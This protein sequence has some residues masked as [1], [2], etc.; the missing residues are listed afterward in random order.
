MKKIKN[1]AFAKLSG[2]AKAFG[3]ESAFCNIAEGTHAGHITVVAKNAIAAANLVVKFDQGGIA[4]ANV[5]DVPAG[6]CTDSGDAGDI[7]DVALPGCAESSFI[8]ISGTDVKEGDN[9]Y[10]SNAGKVVKRAT[11]GSF[12]VGV[13]LT[14]AP[15]GGM[16]EVDP[17]GFGTSSYNIIGCGLH[18]WGTNTVTDRATVT[19]ALD[20]DIVIASIGTIGGNEK[21]VTSKINTIGEIVFY[22]DATGTKGQ[23]TI[24]WII[25]RA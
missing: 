13:A 8:C 14:S 17:Q 10:T 11:I 1:I 25:A 24:N 19:G 5:G 12:K 7:L 18:T 15:A 3:K 21:Y 20:T 16:V 6:V 9:L 23:T 4:V 2:F 22:L